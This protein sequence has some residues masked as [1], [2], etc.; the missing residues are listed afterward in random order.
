MV[1]C[2]TVSYNVTLYNRNVA[3]SFSI[4]L[5]WNYRAGQWN[6]TGCAHPSWR[7]QRALGVA[8][9][10]PPYLCGG[11]W[12]TCPHHRTGRGGSPTAGPSSILHPGRTW[13]RAGMR[14]QGRRATY[15]SS[16]CFMASGRPQMP[17]GREIRLGFHFKSKFQIETEKV[18]WSVVWTGGV[19]LSSCLCFHIS[20]SV[21]VPS[22]VQKE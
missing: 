13:V 9:A 17:S 14:G 16:I 6:H 10:C 19:G 5:M 15:I 3:Y 12:D 7:T 4:L 22:W 8:A 18:S 1:C 2:S 21:A 11:C 20:T